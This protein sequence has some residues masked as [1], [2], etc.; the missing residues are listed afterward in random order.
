MYYYDF[1]NVSTYIHILIYFLLYEGRFYFPSQ[2]LITTMRDGSAG[3]N[4]PSTYS[5]LF[6]DAY[7]SVHAG[8][9]KLYTGKK[10]GTVLMWYEV[11]I[12]KQFH[13]RHTDDKFVVLITY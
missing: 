1:I 7:S 12:S 2:N 6:L 4:S 3:E 13:F 5:P 11:I 10:M 9:V 8:D